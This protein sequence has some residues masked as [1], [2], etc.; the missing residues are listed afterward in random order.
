MGVIYKIEVEN[1]FSADV[2][3]TITDKFHCVFE[4][5]QHTL[6]CETLNVQLKNIGKK[7]ERK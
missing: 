6:D 2:W 7:G 3:K 4:K 1:D 5:K